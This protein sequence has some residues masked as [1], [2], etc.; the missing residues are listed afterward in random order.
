MD[1]DNT[2]FSRVRR[3]ENNLMM[4]FVE[5][6]ALHYRFSKKFKYTCLTHPKITYAGIVECQ[7][8]IKLLLVSFCRCVCLENSPQTIRVFLI[9]DLLG[10]YYLNMYHVPLYKLWDKHFLVLIRPFYTW[11][12]I[13]IILCAYLAIIPDAWSWILLPRLQFYNDFQWV[14]V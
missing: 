4:C 5:I 12:F 2:T 7:L 14:L 13:D 6:Y 9:M 10:F 3:R 11:S 1:I 8:S